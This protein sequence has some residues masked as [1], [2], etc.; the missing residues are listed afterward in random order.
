MGLFFAG[1]G[2]TV[3]EGY[4]LTESAS[5]AT[6]NPP[7][8]TRYGTVGRP[9]PG[10]SVRIAEDGEVWVRGRNVFSGY[11]NAPEAHRRGP[12]GRVAGDG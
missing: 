7:E 12:A 11:L 10:T 1:A 2:V 8:R 4:G 6:A 3:Y 5:A 9:V